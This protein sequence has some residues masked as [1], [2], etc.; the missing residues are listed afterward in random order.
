[1][2]PAGPHDQTGPLALLA[3]PSSR[4]LEDADISVAVAFRPGE[5][6]WDVRV[7]LS[8]R[9]DLPQVDADEL[10][11]RLLDVAGQALPVLSEPSGPLVEVG[12][13]LGTTTNADYRFAAPN[14]DQAP[15]GVEVDYG[16]KAASFELVPT[17]ASSEEGPD[18]GI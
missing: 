10:T 16:D 3:V 8:R 14:S 9:P 4:S 6:S 13:G 2:T 5:P 18:G 7:S 15:G 11:V 1:V 17:E 12:G